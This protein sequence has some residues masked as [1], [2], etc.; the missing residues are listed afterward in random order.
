MAT[1]NDDFELGRWT[2]ARLA[3][4]DRQDP[5]QPETT[6]AFAR[7]QIAKSRDTHHG[8]RW[9]A[10]AVLVA[11]TS[12]GVMAFPPAHALAARC[13]AACVDQSSKLS[14]F[15][16]GRPAA[17]GRAA[18]P[19]V[20]PA[21]LVA[22]DFSLS[23]RSGHA[24]SLSAYRGRVVLLNF[25]ATWC[26]PCKREVPWLV[27]FQRKYKDRGFTVLGLSLDDDGWT[28]LGPYMDDEAITYPVALATDDVVA[29]YGGVGVVPMTFLVDRDGR[30]S[31]KHLG[32]IDKDGVETEIQK[33]LEK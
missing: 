9:A 7:F 13:V 33:A 26:S 29:L 2:D 27:D 24:V 20:A 15:L 4:L 21:L 31:A 32:L 1:R 30:I 14:T 23:D 6:R 10:A 5:S 19:L 11:A 17:P 12:V 16:W 8:T 25:W 28:T 22:P 3:E 18:T